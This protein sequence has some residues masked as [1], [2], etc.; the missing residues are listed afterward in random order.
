MLLLRG[1][2]RGSNGLLR[3]DFDDFWVRILRDICRTLTS[4]GQH[5]G[6]AYLSGRCR[7][8]VSR[9]CLGEIDALIAILAEWKGELERELSPRPL[10]PPKALSD[11]SFAPR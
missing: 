9:E 3:G 10:D 1:T 8:E 11:R 4:V 5:G 2:K 6:F 7:P